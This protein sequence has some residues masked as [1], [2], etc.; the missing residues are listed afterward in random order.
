MNNCTTIFQ[1]KEEK[2]NANI[3]LV[4]E[5]GKQLFSPNEQVVAAT[6]YVVQIVASL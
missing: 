4:R 6:Q 5:R 1:R 3:Y 2:N